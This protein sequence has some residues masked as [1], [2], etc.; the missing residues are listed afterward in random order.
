MLR[1]VRS[2]SSTTRA[3]TT[4]LLFHEYFHGDNGAGLGASHQ[5]GWTGLVADVIRRRPARC[6]PGRV[7]PALGGRSR[8]TRALPGSAS[9]SAPTPRRAAANFAVASRCDGMLC[10]FDDAG[11]ETRCPLG[12]ATATSGTGSSPA[13]GPGSATASGTVR[14]TRAAA[15]QPGQAPARPVRARDRRRGAR[16]D[17][18]VLR[19]RRRPRPPRR[20]TRRPVPR[21]L[22]VDPAVRLGR[23]PP[24]GDAASRRGHLR[25]ARQGLHQLHPGVPEELRG[26]YAGLAHAAAIAHLVDLGVTAVELLPVHHVRARGVPAPSAG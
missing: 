11:T 6:R 24:P 7:V 5:T 19:L 2:A 21:S 8:L 23:R 12:A 18:E 15:L 9:R 4:T 14:T 16:S 20:S 10:L 26:T 25:A 22:V 3:G 1:R 17:P 13:S